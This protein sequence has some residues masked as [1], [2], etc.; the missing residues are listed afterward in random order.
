MSC[1]IC[2]NQECTNIECRRKL[3]PKYKYHDNRIVLDMLKKP[4]ELKFLIKCTLSAT[5]NPERFNPKPVKDFD[6]KEI[7]S[8]LETLDIDSLIKDSKDFKHDR[9]LRDLIGR[10]KYLLLRFIILSCLFQLH[11]TKLIYNNLTFDLY[12]VEHDSIRESNFMKQS[13]IGSNIGSISYLYHGSPILNWHSIMRNGIKIMSGTKFMTS[14]SAYGDGIYLTNL[15]RRSCT[16]AGSKNIVIG[17]YEVIDSAKYM[18]HLD[19]HVVPADNLLLLRYLIYLSNIKDIDALGECM[20][21]KLSEKALN[22]EI[23]QTNKNKKLIARLSK[24]LQQLKI[25]DPQVRYYDDENEIRLR[26]THIK[27]PFNFPISAPIINGRTPL[28][29]TIQS[30]LID[31]IQDVE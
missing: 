31:F 15:L 27:I 28:N 7:K 25:L 30:S 16:F 22:K 23:S 29:W 20:N 9:Q 13:N 17:V 6:E 12:K 11:H 4:D 18:K 1:Y 5:D 8:N 14:G 19:I 3:E 2:K 10:N 26:E 21:N 24:E